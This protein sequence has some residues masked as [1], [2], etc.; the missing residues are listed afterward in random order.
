MLIAML[1]LLLLSFDGATEVRR[2]CDLV[3]AK[4]MRKRTV[5][6]TPPRKA[7]LMSVF[8]NCSSELF[9]VEL[10]KTGNA[11]VVVVVSVV[12]AVVVATLLP[13][14]IGV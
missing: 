11:F 12:V 3:H 10:F 9:S 13:S 14:R 4:M 1:S 8:L 5:T 6:N 7:T 2:Q